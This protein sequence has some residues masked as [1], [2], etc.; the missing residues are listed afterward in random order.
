MELFVVKNKGN[1]VVQGNFS[2]KKV[3]KATRDTLQAASKDGM[4]EKPEYNC[5]QFRWSFHISKGRDHRHNL[6]PVK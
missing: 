2:S 5:Q 3:A 6:S 1:E 4:P